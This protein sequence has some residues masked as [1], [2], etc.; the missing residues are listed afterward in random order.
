[1]S[2]TGHA[3]VVMGLSEGVWVPIIGGTLGSRQ[4]W[5]SRK[6]DAE[7]LIRDRKANG[8]GYP[9]E[10]AVRVPMVALEAAWRDAHR[11]C[12]HHKMSML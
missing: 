9:R 5:L 1:M 2:T 10:R 4:G 3:Y 7:T 8:E 12:I 6:Q 11:P